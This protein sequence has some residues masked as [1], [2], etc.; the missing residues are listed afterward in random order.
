M[1][2]IIEHMIFD[3]PL[4][5]FA[6]ELSEMCIYFFVTGNACRHQVNSHLRQK[7]KTLEE[8]EEDLNINYFSGGLQGQSSN[9]NLR[10]NE[11]RRAGK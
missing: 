6:P 1:I 8:A 11:K 5:S 4:Y 9:P 7:Y 10:T 2:R 3:L